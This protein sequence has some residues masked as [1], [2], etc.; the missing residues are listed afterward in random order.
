MNGSQL[1]KACTLLLAAIALLPGCHS[2]SKPPTPTLVGPDT[3][4]TQ[5]TTVFTAT[6][7]SPNNEGI[8]AV[9]YFDWD[10]GSSNGGY[11][12]GLP[13]EHVYAEPGTYVV[14]CR[15]QYMQQHLDWFSVD[16]RYGDWSNPCTVSIVPGALMR[17]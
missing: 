10:D 15:F 16:T 17:P 2:V 13:Y 6:S 9:T 4:W 11:T 3:G 8:T 7:A 14:K 12:M 1:V 5:V